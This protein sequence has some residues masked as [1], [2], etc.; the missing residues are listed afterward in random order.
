[1]DAGAPSSPPPSN[2]PKVKY[3]VEDPSEFRPTLVDHLGKEKEDFRGFYDVR[4]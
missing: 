4:V 1:M 3:E 2:R